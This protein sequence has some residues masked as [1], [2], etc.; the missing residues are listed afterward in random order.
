MRFWATSLLI[1]VTA[2]TP[3]TSQADLI[4]T[5]FE[6]LNDNLLTFDSATN[7]SWLDWDYTL[8]Q[9]YEDVLARTQ[10]EDDELYGFRYAVFDDFETLISP[11]NLEFSDYV[12]KSNPNAQTLQNLLGET[13]DGSF[14][15]SI[16]ISGELYS[17]N[18]VN[19]FALTV[20]DLSGKYALELN[21]ETGAYFSS[22][23]PNYGHALVKDFSA[24]VVTPTEVPEPHTL[25][26][27]AAGL[28]GLL[29][30]KS[31]KVVNYN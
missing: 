31:R 28:V 20:S 17:S 11:L 6:N 12:K 26:I 29:V 19:V 25:A 9:S 2:I 5:D 4:S 18:R 15:Y 27:F 23:Y 13:I 22:A 16:G 24:E 8:G 7:L 3:F 10:D 14:D 1:T 30:R 21:Y